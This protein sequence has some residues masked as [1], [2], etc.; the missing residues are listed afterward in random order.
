MP[1]RHQVMPADNLPQITSTGNRISLDLRVI[2]EVLSMTPD[3]SVW[4]NQR[5]YDFFDD[6]PVEGLAWECLRRDEGYQGLYQDLVQAKAET[7]PLPR[8]AEQRW[9][10]RFPGKAGFAL[11]ITACALVAFSRSCC[12]DPDAMPR[13]PPTSLTPPTD[14]YR[15]ESPCSRRSLCR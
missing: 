12:F 14:R 7:A 5:A 8:E 15:R 13:I 4:R 6:L 9:G 10:L 3:T 2:C 11:H 1:L